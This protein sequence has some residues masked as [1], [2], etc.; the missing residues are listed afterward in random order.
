MPYGAAESW[1]EVPVIDWVRNVYASATS[2]APSPPGSAAITGT[3]CWRIVWSAAAVASGMPTSS[4]CC[5][6]GWTRTSK[7]GSMRIFATVDFWSGRPNTSFTA[8]VM[9]TA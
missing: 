9:T 8:L 4:D 6:R 1:S 5:V 7:P 3:S 2:P